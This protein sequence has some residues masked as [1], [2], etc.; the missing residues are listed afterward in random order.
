MKFTMFGKSSYS[1]NMVSIFHSYNT[2][3]N[4]SK[5][6]PE[7]RQNQNVTDIN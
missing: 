4:L 2:D 6:E 1:E 3:F 7:T 5:S